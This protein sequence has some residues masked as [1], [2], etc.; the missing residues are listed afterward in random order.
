MKIN[1]KYFTIVGMVAVLSSCSIISKYESP[2]VE[3][4]G[5]FRDLPDTDTVSIASMPWQQIFTDT[6][7]RSLI[8]RGLAQNLDLKVAFARVRQTES[9]YRQSRVDLYPTLNADMSFTGSRLSEA[10]GFGIRTQMKQYNIGVNSSWEADIWGRLSS[11]KRSN[12]AL[13]LSSEAGAKAVRSGLVAD[14]ANLYYSLVTL[15]NQLEIVNR[16]VNNWDAT[17]ATMKKLKDAA[18]V[19]EA[20]VVQSK[21]QKYAVEVTIPTI[22]QQIKQ[23]ENALSILLGNPPDSIR[24]ARFSELSA[25]KSLSVGIPAQ[26]LANRPDVRRSEYNY[27]STFELL[28]ASRAAFYPTLSIT[29]SAGLN[30]L[31]LE[32]LLN[33]TSIAA[34]VMAGLTQPI[35]NRRALKTNKEVAKE[36]QLVAYL[37]YKNTLLNA[38]REV[39]DAL[40]MHA[41][42]IQKLE[43]RE[44][45][46][47][48]LKNS[49][50]Y[51]ERLLSNG[52]ADYL[53]VINARQSLLDAEIGQVDDRLQQ[54]QS[55]VNLYRA[56]GGGSN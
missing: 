27:R 7:L 16:T 4:K 39:S 22:S 50:L 13:L 6:I 23:T 24:R 47:V 49:V 55:M 12:L 46:L 29:A 35:F 48:E 44:L 36:E 52:F 53:E 51:T 54:F 34:N 38:G 41:A 45:Q 8:E 18:R 26:L 42:A 25:L 11:V 14:I 43:L 56:L 2:D 3:V 17:V 9:Y 5:L 19:T 10:Q 33:P 21:A 37:T 20:A 31:S 15:D 32:K 30:S 28:N 1:W 40:A